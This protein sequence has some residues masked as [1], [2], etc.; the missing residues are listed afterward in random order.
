M[1][2]R[3]CGLKEEL[4]VVSSRCYILSVSV[5][6]LGIDMGSLGYQIC[7]VKINEGCRATTNWLLGQLEEVNCLS[8]VIIFS[9]FE[10]D[11]E[12]ENKISRGLSVL[13]KG[14]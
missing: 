11:A 4:D 3:T 13:K 8:R 5:S 1:V 6:S 2:K 14:Y 10:N 12:D 9:V 7:I